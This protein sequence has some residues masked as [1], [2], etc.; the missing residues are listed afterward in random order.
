MAFRFP[1]IPS[2]V[3]WQKEM[4]AGDVIV[5]QQAA[6]KSHR[7]L[8]KVPLA[9]DFAKTDMARKLLQTGVNNYGATAM[10]WSAPSACTGSPT[11]VP[12]RSCGT[13]VASR[14]L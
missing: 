12:R 7:E 2:K 6:G 9:L 8:A 13:G 10:A 3:T 5:L 1:G 11:C 4:E 14:M